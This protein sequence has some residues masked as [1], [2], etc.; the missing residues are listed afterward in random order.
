[1]TITS[2]EQLSDGARELVLYMENTPAYHASIEWANGTLARHYV[3]G[4]FDLAQSAKAFAGGVRS[5][6]KSYQMEHGSSFGPP[7]FYKADRDE[8]GELLASTFA[9]TVRRP[10]IWD[11]LGE[12]AARCLRKH[13]AVT[14]TADDIDRADTST[15]AGS[16]CLHFRSNV[17]RDD[18]LRAIRAGAVVTLV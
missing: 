8:V 2:Y 9:D 17:R 6:A 16:L 12:R 5:A 15:T 14:V 18:V 4:D 1:M 3:R 13:A 7:V 11:D 10:E